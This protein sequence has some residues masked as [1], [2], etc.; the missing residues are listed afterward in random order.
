[1]T[2]TADAKCH[3]RLHGLRVGVQHRTG[4]GKG[5][6]SN[7]FATRSET[8]QVLDTGVGLSAALNSQ[9]DYVR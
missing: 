4:E 5:R 7:R 6:A 3:G 9:V 1:M 8:E 2:A